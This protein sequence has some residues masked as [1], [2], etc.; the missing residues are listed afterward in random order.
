MIAMLVQEVWPILRFTA[1]D[2]TVW[3][4]IIIQFVLQIIAEG[5]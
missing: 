5:F 4:R 2:D 1:I 3:R